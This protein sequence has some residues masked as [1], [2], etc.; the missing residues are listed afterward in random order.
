MLFEAFCELQKVQHFKLTLRGGG[1]GYQGRVQV[2][3]LEQIAATE[4]VEEGS[5][6]LSSEPLVTSTLCGFLSFLQRDV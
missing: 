4:R 1:E 2:R 5:D 6:G 3:E